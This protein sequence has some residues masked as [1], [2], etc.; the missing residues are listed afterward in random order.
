MATPWILVGPHIWKWRR[1]NNP[2]CTFNVLIISRYD[3]NSNTYFEPK[4]WGRNAGFWVVKPAQWQWSGSFGVE[5][6]YNGS[7]PVPTPTRKHSRWL[8]LLLTLVLP[9]ASTLSIIC[10]WEYSLTVD[11]IKKQLPS[12]NESSLAWQVWTSMN[13]S[14]TTS[15]IA[16]HM[17]WK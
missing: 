3:Q 14:A 8:E 4:L 17:D 6:C 1:N 9:S 16:D 5:T 7:V 10:H 13:H 15:V 11:A 12:R 2:K